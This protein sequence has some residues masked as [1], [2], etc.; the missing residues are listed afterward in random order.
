M[1]LLLPWVHIDSQGGECP[2]L[3]ISKCG[4]TSPI[5]P[6]VSTVLAGNFGALHMLRIHL[7]QHGMQY[8]AMH[9]ASWMDSSLLSTN[10]KD[11]DPAWPHLERRTAT[12]K[13]PVSFLHQGNLG[14]AHP[15]PQISRCI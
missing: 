5:E 3:T 10:A 15:L 13:A 12:M 14:E 7:W 6:L 1:L 2:C 4:K 11:T 9:L 8:S